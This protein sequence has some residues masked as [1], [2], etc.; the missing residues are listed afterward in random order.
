MGV[1]YFCQLLVCALTVALSLSSLQTNDLVSYDTIVSTY[2]LLWMLSIAFI[3]CF[4]SSQA[5]AYLLKV[6]DS[7]YG[8]DWFMLP[9]KQQQLFIL[10]MQ[11]AQRE[12]CFHGLGLVDCSLGTFGK[13]TYFSFISST[14][15]LLHVL[16]FRYFFNSR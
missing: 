7:F 8:C 16:L 12:F 11:R 13:V 6:K 9:V 15:T 14:F 2:E 5:T 4:L 3:Y 1:V 10:P